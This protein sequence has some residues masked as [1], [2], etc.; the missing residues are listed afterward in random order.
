MLKVNKTLR[1]RT[2][3]EVRLL[4]QAAKFEP[5]SM[6]NPMF[7]G[8]SFSEAFW[9]DFG[10]VL[11]GQKPRFSHFFRCFFEV[12][13][14]ARSGRPKNRAKSAKTNFGARLKAGPAEC[15]WPGGE[16]ERG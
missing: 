10:T 3:F 6:K 15:A 11:G 7:V 4:Q 13:F 5:K 8:T 1:G 14:E 12:V 9:M 16:I 2:N